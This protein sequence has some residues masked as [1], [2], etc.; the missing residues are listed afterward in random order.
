[1]ARQSEIVLARHGRPQPQEATRISGDGLAAW[2]R[3]YNEAGIT[4]DLPPPEYLRHLAAAS[5][6]VVASDL[7]RSIESAKWLV[8]D[9]HIEPDLRE[10][11]LP[12]AIQVPMCMS[13]STCIGIARVLWFLNWGNS[14]ET[15]ADA[16]ARALRATDRL[17]MLA[18]EHQSVLV[19]GH[20]MFNRFI[21]T[22]LRSRG[23]SGP[24][25][26][27]RAYWSSARFVQNL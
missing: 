22:C 6:R 3:R 8:D 7:P 19:V 27:P 20:G 17:C 2:V 4:R 26:L 13:P 15:V 24:Q 25:I 5:G 1:M 11:G 9:V 23:W 16:R 12:H 18:Q 14:M 10:A 21:A